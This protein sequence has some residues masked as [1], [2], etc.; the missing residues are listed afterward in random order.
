MT[1][2]ESKLEDLVKTVTSLL[3]VESEQD[4][5][6]DHYH[7]ESVESGIRCDNNC[8]E[9]KTLANDTRMDVGE[10]RSG[11]KSLTDH[12]VG[13][14]GILAMLSKEQDKRENSDKELQKEDKALHDRIT[15][16]AKILW[17][18]VGIVATLQIV[19]GIMVTL[20]D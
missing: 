8:G 19:I 20:Y 12:I 5:K 1:N 14:F 10:I 18:G 7:S 11:L 17:I 3:V 16:N 6:L 15:S 13:E 9:L 4:R 2:I